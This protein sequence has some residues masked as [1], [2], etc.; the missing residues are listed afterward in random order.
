MSGEHAKNEK[1]TS[2]GKPE[3]SGSKLEDKVPSRGMKPSGDKHKHKQHEEESTGTTK[4]HKK[5]DNKK[6]KKKI[7]KL[8]YYD[9]YSSM[10]S[11]SYIESTSFK[12]QECKKSKMGHHLT[13]LH[14]I[15][16]DIVEFGAQGPQVGN[17]DY[18]SDEAAQI[19]HFNSQA[20][21]I[22]LVSLFSHLVLEGKLNANHVRARIRNSRRQRLHK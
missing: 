14:E 20:T 13:S 11:T 17:E 10:S 3:S 16:W 15:I 21:T 5:K 19:Q 22:L 12:R 2:G 6:K 8:V 18:D 9:T 1:V 4:L 7:K